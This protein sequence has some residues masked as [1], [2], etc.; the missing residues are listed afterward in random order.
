MAEPGYHYIRTGFI[1]GRFA[2][3]LH[4]EYGILSRNEAAL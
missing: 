3:M 2:V 4:W 1:V